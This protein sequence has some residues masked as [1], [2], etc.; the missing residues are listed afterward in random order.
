MAK[1]AFWVTAGQ[2]LEAKALAGLRLAARLKTAR[3]QEVQVYLF[4]PGV[5]LAVSESPAVQS[6]LKDLREAD[7]A[8][9][10]CPANVEN[11]GLDTMA[12]SAVGVGLR[13]AGEVMIEL[14]ENGY[15]VIGI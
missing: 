14:V 2:D 11:M 5:G 10:A 13:P 9:G 8:V 3:Q 12:V 7:V 4:G 1:I 15:Q 6:A